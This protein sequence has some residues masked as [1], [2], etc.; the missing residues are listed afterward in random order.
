MTILL[1]AG[2]KGMRMQTTMMHVYYACLRIHHERANWHTQAAAAEKAEEDAEEGE[3]AGE[4]EEA[5]A[6]A[7]AAAG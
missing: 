2:R 7:K 3:P 6:P 1:P 4:D 5:G